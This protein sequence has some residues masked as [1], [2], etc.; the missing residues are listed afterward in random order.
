MG[1]I[2]KDDLNAIASSD[3]ILILSD[4]SDRILE[5]CNKIA[6][7]EA[8]GYLAG[9]YNIETIFNTPKLYDDTIDTYQ[10]G[11]RLYVVNS[12]TTEVTHYSCIMSGM[13]TGTTITDTSYFKEG[14]TRDYKLLEV[15]MSISLFY[16]HKRLSPNN[17]PNHRIVSYDGN[18]NDKIMSA[19]KWLEMIQKGLIQPFGWLLKADDESI[20]DP[21]V[22]EPS[23]LLGN[24]PSVG[25]MWGNEIS[26]G[27]N[28]YYYHYNNIPDA[29][30][31]I[32]K[33]D[34]TV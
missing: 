30:L 18:G 28:Q 5:Q 10:I 33:D 6:C 26:A 19:I 24:D 29:N 9:K 12:A 27:M 7:D 4:A 21:D 2:L 15:V 20:P 1:F 22:Q 25:M 3:D 32:K 31:I 34:E 16:I 23:D 11:D 17:I 13:T 8:K 14:D